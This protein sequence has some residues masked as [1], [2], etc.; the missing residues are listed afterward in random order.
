MLGQVAGHGQAD[1][2]EAAGLTLDRGI[3]A[4]DLAGQI[5]ERTAAVAGIDGGIRLQEVFVHVHVQAGPPLGADDAV[6]DGAGQ[7]ERCADG[8]DVI[9]DVH[10]VAV[11]KLEKR[12]LGPLEV[13]LDNGQVGAPIAVNILGNELSAIFEMDDDLIGS[14]DDVEVGQNDAAGVNEEAGTETDL[15]LEVFG[16]LEVFEES[17]K[18]FRHVGRQRWDIAFEA[19]RLLD[20]GI[21]ADDGGQDFLDDVAIGIQLA[22]HDHRFRVRTGTLRKGGGDEI[23]AEHKGDRKGEEGN[24]PASH[25]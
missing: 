2:L 14:G 6:R 3:D 19:F 10:G 1:A 9:A 13:E 18:F 12:H 8:Q 5:D 20:L 22:R 24:C 7:P 21:D 16:H 17:A 15:R 4:D 23:G 11:A 25:L